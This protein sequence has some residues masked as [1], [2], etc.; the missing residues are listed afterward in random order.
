MPEK[1]INALFFSDLKK[2]SNGLYYQ[3]FKRT[4][5]TGTAKEIFNNKLR[6]EFEIVDGVIKREI[7]HTFDKDIVFPKNTRK[8]WFNYNPPDESEL[9]RI[10]NF[11]RY[12][13]FDPNVGKL[14]K[15]LTLEIAEIKEATRM[16][17]VYHYLHRGRTM[18]QLHYWILIDGIKVGVLSFAYPRLSAELFNFSSMNILELAR[19]WISSDVQ[20]H[21]FRS[22]AK[23]THHAVSV[24][25][26]A[27][28]KALRRI[29]VDWYKKYMLEKYLKF[30]KK[31]SNAIDFS[32]LKQR[33][34][35]L[36]YQQLKRTPFTGTAKEILDDSDKPRKEIEIV[37]GVIKREIMH[38][39]EVFAIVSW[40]DNIHHEG[41]VYKASNFE[42][43]KKDSGGLYHGKRKRKDGTYNLNNHADYKN[44]K[45][46]WWYEFKSGLTVGQKRHAQIEF[47]K[48]QTQK[49]KKKKPFINLDLFEQ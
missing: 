45:T 10:E 47:K 6:K 12:P 30:Q 14:S 37:D 29:Q 3:K 44:I 31:A 2:R 23:S 7:S 32:D 43:K 13:D 8:G 33:T 17:V 36:Y 40:A 26:C 15:R 42:K 18:A 1:E 48:E 16:L 28:G 38:D 19:L 35:G 22:S 21:K 11:G 41:T 27:I 34:D 20:D 24:A 25:S 4:P 9:E 39:V 46:L 49:S 5:F